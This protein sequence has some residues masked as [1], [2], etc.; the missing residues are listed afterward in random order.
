[1]PAHLTRDELTDTLRGQGV[2]G[3]LDGLFAPADAGRVVDLIVN[4]RRILDGQY[5]TVQRVDAED[6]EY[7]VTFIEFTTVPGVIVY[8]R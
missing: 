6:G 5:V 8:V 1:M 4:P 7:E 2:H 3:S